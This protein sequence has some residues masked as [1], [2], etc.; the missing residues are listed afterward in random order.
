MKRGIIIIRMNV[1]GVVESQDAWPAEDGEEGEEAGLAHV[2][3]MSLP[4]PCSH[5]DPSLPLQGDLC[6]CH[7]TRSEA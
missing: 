4:S 5:H 3:G 6:I 1:L 2:Q 7:F